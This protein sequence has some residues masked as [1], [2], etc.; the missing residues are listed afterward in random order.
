[1][2]QPTGVQHP[3]LIDRRTLGRPRDPQSLAAEEQRLQAAWSEVRLNTDLIRRGWNTSRYW[4]PTDIA[5]RHGVSRSSV[6]KM[7]K[8][9]EHYAELGWEPPDAWRG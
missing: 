5:K 9:A 3:Y 6:V 1:M 7:L 2:Y 4:S 8:K